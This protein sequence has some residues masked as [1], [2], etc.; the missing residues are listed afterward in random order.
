MKGTSIGTVFMDMALD[1]GDFDDSLK[2]TENQTDSLENSISS[3]GS[4][5]TKVFSAAV[6]AKFL[7]SSVDEAS[8]LE[9]AMIGLQSI[10]E[11][12]GG[13]FATAQTFIQDYI[14]DGLIT[15][16]EA[17]TAYKNLLAR[18][19]S[20]TQIVETLNNLKDAAAFGRQ[21]SLALGEAVASAT[22]G[23]KNENS[24]LVDNAGVTKNVSVMWEDY[25]ESIGTTTANLTDAQKIQA[26]VNGIMTETQF[27]QGDAIKLADTY[28]GSVSKL[29]ATYLSFQQQL[30]SAFMPLFTK[31]V[32]MM[33]VGL[34]AVIFLTEGYMNLNPV[35]QQFLVGILAA[36]VTLP[37]VSVAIWTVT[38]AKLV[39]ASV[40]T[41]LS[42]RLI[43]MAGAI[44]L[45]YWQIAL[46]AGAVF[47]AVQIIR[48]LTGASDD[49]S[50][51]ATEAASSVDELSE[52]LSELEDSS[53]FLANFDKITNIGD[54][55]TST[56]FISDE[57]LQS[58]QDAIEYKDELGDASFLT[59][60]GEDFSDMFDIVSS[61]FDLFGDNWKAGWDV[62]VDAASNKLTDIKDTF[63]EDFDT[64]TE[65]W[66][67]FGDNWKSGWSAMWTDF[68]GSSFYKYWASLGTTVT[69]K[70][71]TMT[72]DWDLFGD[73]WKRG[74]ASIVN[75]TK[76]NPIVYTVEKVES[77]VEKLTE[78]WDL[79][80]DN[81]WRGLNSIFKAKGGPV[82]SNS[83]YIVGEEGPEL[84]VPSGNGNI[85]T[86]SK[87]NDLMSGGS[88][89]GLTQM[90]ND[91]PLELTL[92]IAERTFGKIAA[93][94]INKLSQEQ[95]GT[96]IRI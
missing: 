95:G 48:S 38:K 33:N 74:W 92:K 91:R 2:D 54:D 62:I 64:I 8:D 55:D 27:Q 76:N 45:A 6:F 42:K 14:S 50:S 37:A 15:A 20:D 56:S 80:G 4:T 5:M 60:F 34:E 17:A 77:N 86:N 73:N 81:W 30:G 24:I 93:S 9:S 68:K 41:L 66:D 3:L 32:N 72:D 65:G 1:K 28:S 36:A 22:E 16:T 71:N 88:S 43:L 51:S 79:F 10:V 47:A 21:G 46:I 75:Y 18:G 19:Y 78:G 31:V 26:E 44:N 11:G 89:S 67:L 83:P 29:S 12:T 53:S 35:L 40:T 13:S 7:T 39:W 85:M 58:L 57:D 49:T 90:N 23:L 94:S 82:S 52:S 63:K 59:D 69:T 61:D 70:I 25:A 96:V 87:T 84:F